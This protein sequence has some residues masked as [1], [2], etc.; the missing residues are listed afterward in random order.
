VKKKER[1]ILIHQGHLSGKCGRPLI[2]CSRLIKRIHSDGFSSVKLSL[3]Q[4]KNMIEVHGMLQGSCMN[5][6]KAGDGE[7]TSTVCSKRI[8]GSHDNLRKG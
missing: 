3:P 2:K 4:K 7:N 8:V 6:K 1:E 5:K